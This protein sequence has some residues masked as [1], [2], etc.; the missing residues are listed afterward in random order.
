MDV[1]ERF[2]APL[3]IDGGLAT[4]L[5]R[6]GA[7][8]SD[9][10]WSARLLADDPAAIIAAHRAFLDIG[11]QVI[12]TASYQ[13]T[14]AG[15]VR[16]GHDP[17]RAAELLRRREK[18]VGLSIEDLNQRGAI[19]MGTPDQVCASLEPYAEAGVEE[20]TI[21][22]HPLDDIDAMHRGVNLYAEKVMPRF[23]PG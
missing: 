6:L 9:E 21:A 3:V 13:A 4:Q 17:G 15:F 7:N 19:L 14:V 22:F 16:Q 23:A 5:E 10:L 11:A 18:Y 12:T 8:L 2:R 20:L 1:V